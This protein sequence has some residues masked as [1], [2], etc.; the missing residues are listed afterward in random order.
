MTLVH[1]LI[2]IVAILLALSLV[3]T[4]AWLIEQ[5]SGNAGWIDTVWTFGLGTVGIASALIAL[6][7][8][9]SLTQRQALVAGLVLLW[10]LRL[11]I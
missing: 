11:G 2:G 6:P 5:R 9:T 8:E 4:L 10:S 1:F 7:S 3:M